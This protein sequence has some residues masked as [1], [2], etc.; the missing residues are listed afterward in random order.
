MTT[1]V[2]QVSDL[3]ALLRH[4]PVPDLSLDLGEK[5]HIHL[6][7]EGGARLCTKERGGNKKTLTRLS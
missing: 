1:P 2:F 6:Q 4:L 5:K 7:S 3:P